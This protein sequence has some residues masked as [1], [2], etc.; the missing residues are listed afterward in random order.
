MPVTEWLQQSYF[1]KGGD[2]ETKQYSDRMLK[3]V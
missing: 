3:S 2:F 1:V